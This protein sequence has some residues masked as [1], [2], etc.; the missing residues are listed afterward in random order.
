MGKKET[1]ASFRVLLV[2]GLVAA[3]TA[4]QIA[5]DSGADPDGGGG[6]AM[7]GPSY[8]FASDHGGVCTTKWT[9]AHTV[10]FLQKQSMAMALCRRGAQALRA[11]CK[12]SPH[13]SVEEI[14]ELGESSEA[15]I[16]ATVQTISEL[17]DRDESGKSK[18]FSK[19]KVQLV[20]ICKQGATALALC[21]KG[22]IQVHHQCGG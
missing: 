11:Q 21:N 7:A 12:K 17:S 2:L 5:D 14:D 15:A 16:E 19:T 1:M 4:V 6:D 10:T 13:Q 22:A 20:A 3:C 9:K 18:F 8:A